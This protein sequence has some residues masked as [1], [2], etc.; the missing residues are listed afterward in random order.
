MI[1]KKDGV[2]LITTY[3]VIF[4]LL[5]LAGA[6]L[7]YILSENRISQRNVE[8]VQGLYLA[9]AGIDKAKVQLKADYYNTSG[10]VWTLD[11]GQYVSVDIAK[12]DSRRIV[13]STA[14]I[15]NINPLLPPRRIRSIEGIMRQSIPDHFF[16]NAIYGAGIVDFNGNAYSVTGDVRYGQGIDYSNNNVSG[17]IHPKDPSIYPL[18]RLDFQALYNVSQRQ[19]NVYDATRLDAVKKGS[20]SFP[21]SFWFSSPSDPLDPTTGTPNVVYVL[22]DLILR[23]S[24]GTVG[25][26]YVVV[27][28]VLTNPTGIYD[29]TINGNG[30]IDGCIY[31]TGDFQVNGG[32][33]NL[34]I[35]GGVWAGGE[36]EL[37]GNATV[38][39]NSSYMAAL[40]G[41]SW[42]VADVQIISW[43]ELP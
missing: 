33:G 7:F 24:I 42:L 15:P 2:I 11:N 1:K 9:E 18:A 39:Y 32:G 23:G 10:I 21:A 25:G 35:N 34:N 43:K 6:F 19:G 26:F 17:T 5:I 31:T 20:D 13:E 28:D 29:A 40:A 41:Q 14:Y 38:N 27:G 22:S 4:V 8:R 36:V 30:M 37:N 16:D 12:S 3:A